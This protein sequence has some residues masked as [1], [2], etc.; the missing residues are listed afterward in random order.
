MTENPE[1]V[2][3]GGGLAGL[4][5]AWLLGRQ[6]IVTRVIEQSAECRPCFKAE[7][8]EPFQSRLMRKFG[9]L[10]ERRPNS[11]PIEEIIVRQG[12]RRWH[13]AAGDEYGIRYHETVNRLRDVVSGCA[14]IQVNKVR[15]VD[16]PTNGPVVHLVDGISIQPRL[17]II[18]SGGNRALTRD[19]GMSQS[20][21]ARTLS[22]LSFGFD[23]ER[24]DGVPFRFKGFNY[25]SAMPGDRVGF[26]TLFR[27]GAAMRAN[28]F[29]HW[30]PKDREVRA[31]RDAPVKE[32]DRLF[33]GIE[34]DIGAVRIKGKLEVG[35]T[36]YYR[37]KGVDKTGVVVIGDAYQ[38][39][40]PATGTGLDKVLTDVHVLCRHLPDW[41]ATD[42]MG[43]QKIARFYRDPFKRW[44]DD[45]S[46][47]EWI[48][49]H[50]QSLHPW[51]ARPRRYAWR[52]GQLL[53]G[54]FKT[55][56]G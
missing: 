29:T 33:P 35:V 13:E 9:L 17:V 48:H 34:E 43:V 44:V 18:A 49:S 39:V 23:L 50:N 12:R 56:L 22:S 46:R 19:L 38:S 40:S 26:V 21:G 11:D 24:K 45:R 6:G 25:R 55:R 36:H 41:L 10:D 16:A 32:L 14:E 28:L 7:K 1:I 31:F 20:P 53:G 3:I 30:V 8:L 2:V 52:L 54:Q 42:G 37:L 15:R 27:I 4:C 51:S 47:A 5:A